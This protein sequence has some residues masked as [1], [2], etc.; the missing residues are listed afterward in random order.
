M[1]EHQRP[2]QPQCTTC[3]HSSSFHGN[4]P[5]HACRAL[6]CECKALVLPAVPAKN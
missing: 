6:G 3:K 1:S 2:V 5:G 4:T